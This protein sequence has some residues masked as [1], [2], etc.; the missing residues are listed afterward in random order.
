MALWPVSAGDVTEFVR[1]CQFAHFYVVLTTN[2][3][4]G[5]LG[6]PLDAMVVVREAELQ[7]AGDPS[8][9]HAAQEG[10]IQVAEGDEG[11]YHV[12]LVLFTFTSGPKE[13]TS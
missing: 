13:L 7:P 2:P 9:N 12:F 4:G 6:N 10:L 3:G 5:Q 1:A 11:R 8:C